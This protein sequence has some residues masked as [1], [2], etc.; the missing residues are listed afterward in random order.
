MGCAYTHECPLHDDLEH[1]I[2]W[3]L[4]LSTHLPTA[5]KPLGGTRYRDMDVSEADAVPTGQA[6]V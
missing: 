3:T 5:A 1:V 4:Y 6:P 2:N